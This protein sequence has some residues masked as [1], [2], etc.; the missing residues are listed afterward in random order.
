MRIFG[1]LILTGLAVLSGC[2]DENSSIYIC[3][4]GLFS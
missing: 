1:S 4:V 3:L 2:V